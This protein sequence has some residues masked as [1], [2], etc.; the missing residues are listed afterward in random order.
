MTV[1][2]QLPPTTTAGD[3]STVTFPYN[4]KIQDVADLDVTQTIVATGEDTTLE[5]VSSTGIGDPAGGT[6]T[7]A[8]APPAGSVVSVDN[9]APISQP[10]E[11]DGNDIYPKS[12]EDG[13]DRKTIENQRQQ[14]EIN[15]TLR[16]HVTDSEA[17]TLPH[18]SIRAD[19]LVGFD[20][21]GENITMVKGAAASQ[22]Y[23]D[24]AE[25]QADRAVAAAT[26]PYTSGEQKTGAF[27]PGTGES[28][29]L[30]TYNNASDAAVTL[31]ALSGLAAGYNIGIC[32]TAGS[33]DLTISAADSALIN[34][35]SSIVLASDYLCLDFTVND[36]GDE[37]VTTDKAL[38]GLPVGTSANN[39]VALD[40]NAMLPEL[41]AT[42]LINVRDNTAR[43]TALIS[44]I[45][46]DIAISDPGGVYGGIISDNFISDTL[47]VSTNATYDAT[48]DYYSNAAETVIASAA[49]STNSSG[50]TGR[51][52]RQRIAAAAISSG[53]QSVSVTFK[54]SSSAGLTIGSAYIGIAAASG[55][56]F[57]F[58]STPVQLL[59]SESGSAVISAGATATSDFSSLDFEGTDDLIVAF[60]I[61]AGDIQFGS[62]SANWNAY[63]KT[64]DEASTVD[65]TGYTADT[66]KTY[67][68]TGVSVQSVSDMTLQSAAATLETANPS[69]ITAMFRVEDIDPVTNGTDRVISFSIDNGVTF[70]A[71]TISVLGAYGDDDTL[72]KATANVEAQTGDQFVMKCVTANTKSQR[73]K[74]YVAVPGY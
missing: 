22:S 36:A 9:K 4:F 27:M 69:D 3:G 37:W 56:A 46:S 72:I 65:A 60:Y 73:I 15:R 51:T 66:G 57:D 28:L 26:Y 39:I 11:F 67:G 32:R 38:I 13:L 24:Q 20:A 40:Q 30:F 29:T 54:A 64:G 47:S 43:D 68:V 53:G 49:A 2:N 34:G 16:L 50:N 61:S 55:D 8:S 41:D 12:V 42:N 52:V 70:S 59:F 18:K 25:A 48:G 71:A 23:V 10:Q 62:P 33:G 19:A 63:Y 7:F 35:A 44:Y 45:K 58:A 6:V 14:S 21:T 31:P 5:I 74:Q 1:E 17:V